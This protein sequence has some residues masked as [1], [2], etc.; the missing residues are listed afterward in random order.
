MHLNSSKRKPNEYLNLSVTL[1]AITAIVAILLSGVNFFT[2]GKIEAIKQEKLEQAMM[3]VLPDAASFEDVFETVNNEWDEKT[4]LLG[5]Q[6]AKNEK[7]DIIGLCVEVAAKGY[8]D[9][10]DMIV[11]INQDGEITNV[12]IISLSDTPGIGTQIE[13]E[14]YQ[15]QFIGKSGILTAV[16][17][18]ANGA[19]E[20]ALISGASY[21]SGGFTD[22]VNAALHAYKIFTEE[23]TK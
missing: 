8:S 1:F 11:G 3:Y 18:A 6:Q 21:S 19:G 16:K 17:G 9:E 20:V 12:S 5:V 4:T 15:K 22:G 10:I 14:A 13:D 7:G 2:S 23:E